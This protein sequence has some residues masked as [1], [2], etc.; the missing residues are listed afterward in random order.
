MEPARGIVGPN[1]AGF[2]RTWYQLAP[3]LHKSCHGCKSSKAFG[4][5]SN[6]E[7]PSGLAPCPTPFR[8]TPDRARPR[9]TAYGL[10]HLTKLP[11]AKTYQ[12]VSC[13]SCVSPRCAGQTHQACAILHLASHAAGVITHLV[14]AQNDDVSH[15]IF[16][17]TPCI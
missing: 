6:P 11:Y 15:V 3:N 12:P 8:V 7:T 5:D 2:I 17:H 1:F 4:R 16:A 14:N 13:V 9:K 10:P